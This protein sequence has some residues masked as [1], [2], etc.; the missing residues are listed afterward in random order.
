MPLKMGLS[1]PRGGSR[2]DYDGSEFALH[3]TQMNGENP[4]NERIGTHLTPE[5]AQEIHKGFMGTFALY[6]VIAVVAHVL[7]WA[8]KPWLPL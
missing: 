4:M 1:N 6:T 3:T 8:N 7:L 5:E 2:G